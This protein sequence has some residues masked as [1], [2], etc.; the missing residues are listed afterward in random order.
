MQQDIFLVGS[1]LTR[2]GE[3]WDKSLR[4]LM[5]EAVEA[6][7]ASSG[8]QAQDVDLIIVANMLAEVTNN[9]AHM[10]SLASSLLPHHPPSLRVEAAC[11]S[12]ALAINTAC[13][14]LESGRA[15]TVLVLGV[16]KMTD[17]SS[18]AISQALMGA[19][20][21]EL[22]A[23]SGLT[24]PGIF[25]LIAKRYMYEFGLTREQ[26]SIVSSVHHKNATENAFA[27]FRYELSPEA[28]SA[29]PLVSD[30]LRLLDCSPV[31]D[32]AAACILSTA[33]RSGMRLAAS[34]IAS[35]TLSITERP[36]IVSF[37]AT[38]AA[39]EQALGE[40]DVERSDIRALETHDCF[41]IAAV[42]NMEDLGFAK[43][44]EGIRI[45]EDLYAGRTPMFVNAGGGLKAC[46]HPVA[47]TGIKQLIDVGKS[48]TRARAQY[49]LAHNFGGAGA[50][51]GIH[52][53]ENTHV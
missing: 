8:L 49:G 28:V 2:F 20:D 22:D 15:K 1:G 31:S 27:Q 42:I 12:G 16:E 14:F 44:G 37:P 10:A 48:L 23:P 46:G 34:Q 21:S 35:D 53:L 50:T 17:V 51:C 18:D 30:P 39:M 5:S 4:D 7:L 11:G 26:L 52:I 3:W 19:A 13:A 45:Y 6:A 33:H 24:F 41:S 38:R 25:G 29:S 40:A 36:T 32:G 47:A 43:E 9:Q